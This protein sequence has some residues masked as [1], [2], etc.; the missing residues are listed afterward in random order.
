MQPFRFKTELTDALLYLTTAHVVRVWAPSVKSG[1]IEAKVTDIEIVS[2]RD[3]ESLAITV[4]P[5][6]GSGIVVN[7]GAGQANVSATGKPWDRII[8]AD[9]PPSNRR[10]FRLSVAR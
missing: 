2:N 1:W 5:A 4:S 9:Y 3:D 8:Y 7:A 10:S 6:T